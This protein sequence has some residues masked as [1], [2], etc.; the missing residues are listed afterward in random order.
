MQIWMI[1]N[2]HIILIYYTINLFEV[3]IQS[4]LYK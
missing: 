4:Y 1:E 3:T 2:N